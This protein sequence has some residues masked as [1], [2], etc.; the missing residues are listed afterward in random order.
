MPVGY[1]SLSAWYN[2][3]RELDVMSCACVGGVVSVIIMADSDPRRRKSSDGFSCRLASLEVRVPGL[4][5]REEVRVSGSV[6]SLGQWAVALSVPLAP[7]E[8]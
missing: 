7:R 2:N 4:A 8:R 6:P 1:Q 3:K 5:P